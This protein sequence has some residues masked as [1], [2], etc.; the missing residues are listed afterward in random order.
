MKNYK[1][2]DLTLFEGICVFIVILFVIAGTI[3][4]LFDILN[5]GITWRRCLR[6]GIYVFLCWYSIIG[7]K[8]PHGNLL[9]YLFLAFDCFVLATVAH[10]LEY[11]TA[12]MP[13]H[14]VIR[15]LLYCVVAVI[16][17]YMAG[18][19]DRTKENRI[20]GTIVFVCLFITAVLNI[21]FSQSSGNFLSSMNTTILGLAIL[22]SYMIRYKQ[23][24]EAGLQDK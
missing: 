22:T 10:I 4:A 23:H 20:L 1:N 16:V 19:L 12:D 5:Q 6:L 11:N 21:I 18:R 14:A 15:V 13:T 9:K 7:Y 8:K 3:N 24:K 2:Y 17:P